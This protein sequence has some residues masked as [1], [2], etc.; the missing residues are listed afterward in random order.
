MRKT[1]RFV[2][3][4]VFIGCF[5]GLVCCPRLVVTTDKAEAQAKIKSLLQERLT[6]LQRIQQIAA[7]EFKNGKIGVETLREARGSLL[8]AKLE[9]CETKEERLRVLQDAVTEAEAWDKLVQA[10]LKGGFPRRQVDTFRVRAY[11]LD[12]R[13]NLERARAE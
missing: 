12:C 11:L 9:L 4:A 8:K 13:I 5:A 1:P 6:M 3:Q 7:T 2:C 10:E